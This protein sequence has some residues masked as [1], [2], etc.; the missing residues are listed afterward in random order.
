MTYK[1]LEA[2]YTMR[3]CTEDQLPLKI[4]LYK[5][6][7]KKKMIIKYFNERLS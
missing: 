6:I 4:N 3:T 7:I 1:G 2:S 5:I